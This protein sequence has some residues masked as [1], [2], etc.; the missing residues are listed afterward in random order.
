MCI[1]AFA[2]MKNH[3]LLLMLLATNMAVVKAQNMTY[4]EK[5]GFPKG[6]K[7]FVLHVDDAGMSYEANQGTI[8][9]TEEGIAN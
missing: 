5:L 7:V 6:K 3:L 2:P 9:A 1:N 4:A 8:R